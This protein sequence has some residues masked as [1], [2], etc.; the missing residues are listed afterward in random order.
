M[1]LFWCLVC[2][3]LAGP[4][5]GMDGH[6]AGGARPRRL[7]RFNFPQCFGPVAD[8][9]IPNPRYKYE[10]EVSFLHFGGGDKMRVLRILPRYPDADIIIVHY[11][12]HGSR[13]QQTGRS[14]F[15]C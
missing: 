10:S 2:A 13:W 11:F 7:D 15:A 14:C 4:R 5:G 8:P 1:D 12:Q 6:I 3:T 9:K